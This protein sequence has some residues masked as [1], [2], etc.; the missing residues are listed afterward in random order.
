MPANYRRANPRSTSHRSGGFTLLEL[1]V[2]IT[3]FA[4]VM[5][6]IVSTFL[7][8]VHR[9]TQPIYQVRAAELGQAM[10]QDVMTRAFDQNSD[11]SGTTVAGKYPYCGAIAAGVSAEVSTGACSSILGPET[12]ESYPQFND[13]DDYNYFCAHP[14]AG[15]VLAAAQSLN[16]SL[17]QYYTVAVCVTNAPAF[18]GQAT[19]RTDV[20]KQITVT[21]TTPAG[22]SIPFT[23]YRSNY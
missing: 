13:V 23:S 11:R 18:L 14:I 19:N 22:E 8:I 3:I 9:Q 6:L 21:V 5:T 15:D 20:A 17:Y 2:G 10:L 1:V 4:I 16:T 7:P 12:G